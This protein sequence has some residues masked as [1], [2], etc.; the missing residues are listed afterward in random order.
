MQP[1]IR[2]HQH[3]FAGTLL[4]A[5]GTLVCVLCVMGA[6]SPVF[7]HN[8]WEPEPEETRILRE[9][10]RELCADIMGGLPTPHMPREDQV[11]CVALKYERAEKI[12]ELFRNG[13][14][15]SRSDE[16]SGIRRYG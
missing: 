3:N 15:K 8:H 14:Q 11:W 2:L 6:L 9:S 10:Y 1:A 7:A 12:P 4:E 16:R 13:L 5:A